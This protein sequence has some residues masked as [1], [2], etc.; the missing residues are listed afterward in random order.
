MTTV[1]EFD[2]DPAIAR[3]ILQAC[4]DIPSWIAAVDAGRPYRDRDRLLAEAERLSA[5]IGWAEVEHALARHPRIGEKAAAAGQTGTEAAWSATEQS[6]IAGSDVADL[7]SGNAAY[8][9]RF[10]HIFLIC[11]AG[12][13]GAQI[14]DR[15]RQRRATT[16]SRSSPW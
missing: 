16:R 14:L 15:L 9:A 12:L 8:E 4:L 1:A 13:S 6:G 5:G 2:A 11:A 10:G 3:E 7:A